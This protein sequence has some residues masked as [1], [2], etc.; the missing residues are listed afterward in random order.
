MF[1][2]VNVSGRCLF[3][4]LLFHTPRLEFLFLSFLSHLVQLFKGDAKGLGHIS[5]KRCHI[6]RNGVLDCRIHFILNFVVLKP[7]KNIY[8][9]YKID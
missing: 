6:L 1:A 3:S 7:F 5:Y 2:K 8:N 4:G 9:F